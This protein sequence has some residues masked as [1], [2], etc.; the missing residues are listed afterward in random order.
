ML[1]LQLKLIMFQ[2]PLPSCH[3]SDTALHVLDWVV[4]LQIGDEPRATQLAPTCAF[5]AALKVQSQCDD[6]YLQ[7][8]LTVIM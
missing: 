7:V 5:F 1:V 8:G 6:R 2:L 4:G 3:S